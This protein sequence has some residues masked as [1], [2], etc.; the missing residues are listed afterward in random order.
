MPK[1]MLSKAVKTRCHTGFAKSDDTSGTKARTIDVSIEHARAGS[2][3][4]HTLGLARLADEASLMVV[5]RRAVN[6]EAMV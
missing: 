3:R 5:G 1:K 2:I 6:R 4:N